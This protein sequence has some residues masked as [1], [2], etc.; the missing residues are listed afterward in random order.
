MT[1]RDP[2][3]AASGPHV[4]RV[5][6]VGLADALRQLGVLLQA[7]RQSRFFR[8]CGLLALGIV[9]VIGLNMV[10]QVRLNAWQGDFFNALEQRRLDDLLFQV[11][12]FGLIIACLLTLVVGETW[13]REILEVRM[14]EWLT[15][16][17]LDQWV[18]GKRPYLLGFAGEIAVNP[19]QRMQADALQLTELTIALSIG[20]L[21]SSLLLVSFL[22]VLWALSGETVFVFLGQ[23]IRVPGYLVWCALLYALSGSWLTWRVGR[24]GS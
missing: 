21:R 6:E 14:R 13:L 1:L 22:G 5:L 4:A 15:R 3:A 7:L 11:V 9:A 17:L 23:D 16:D 10:G 20:L 18:V 12:V 8:P 24:S 19:D 2:G